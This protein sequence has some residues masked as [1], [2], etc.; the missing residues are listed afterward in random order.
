MRA[1]FV[2]KTQHFA[3][4]NSITITETH[5]LAIF[6]VPAHIDTNVICNRFFYDC[7][8]YRWITHRSQRLQTAVFGVAIAEAI[9]L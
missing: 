4:L 9:K 6:V 1:L 2:I 7:G 3:L 8:R 5:N